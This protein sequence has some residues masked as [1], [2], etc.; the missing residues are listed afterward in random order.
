[1][2]FKID[3]MNLKTISASG[4]YQTQSRL[5]IHW[6]S[7]EAFDY[8]PNTLEK[9]CSVEGF[10]KRLPLFLP[11]FAGPK[12][13]QG[14]KQT[15][16]IQDLDFQK[17]RWRLKGRLNVN[18]DLKATYCG[19]AIFFLVLLLQMKKQKYIL[20]WALV[21]TK[22][23]HFIVVFWLAHPTRCQFSWFFF[24]SNF[25]TFSVLVFSSSN[26]GIESVHCNEKSEI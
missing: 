13:F 19:N 4:T 16:I 21:L 8:W 25:L 9:R 18:S 7:Q 24:D 2:D 26:L 10:I 6:S 14:L 3:Q 20:P 15:L 11:R 1:M 5:A 17:S 12:N 23:P 22:L